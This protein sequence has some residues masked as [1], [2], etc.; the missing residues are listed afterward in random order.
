MADFYGDSL[1]NSIDVPAERVIRVYARGGNDTVIVLG[2]IWDCELWGEA[3][4]D[5]LQTGDGAPGIR[6]YLAGGTG[7]DTMVGGIGADVFVVEN[8]GDLVLDETA[9]DGDTVGVSRI[10][11][12]KLSDTL[13]NLRRSGDGDFIGRG[14]ALD[15]HMDAGEG[16]E[17]LRGLVGNDTLEGGY[18]SSTTILVGGSGS[19]LLLNLSRHSAQVTTFKYDRVADSNR[20]HGEDRINGLGVNDFIDLSR[21]DAN[22]AT[23]DIDESF[24]F[25][26]DQAFGADATGQVRFKQITDKQYVLL[27]STDADPAAEMRITIV[28]WVL[29]V[30]TNFIL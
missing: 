10:R 22:A 4:D 19:D 12:Y 8:P 30:E 18:G 28:N 13:E 23:V 11:S 16:N 26:G 14:N 1:D 3:G 29:P 25:I 20:A 15:N 21:I 24:V 17:V 27:V 7:A 2:D 5:Y 9:G 6:S